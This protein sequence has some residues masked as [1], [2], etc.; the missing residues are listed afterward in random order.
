M[1]GG[2]GEGGGAEQGKVRRKGDVKGGISSPFNVSVSKLLLA[3]QTLD[4]F[5]KRSV[6]LKLQGGASVHRQNRR[7][8][9]REI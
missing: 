8:T 9:V 4:M 6:F 3:Q 1:E 5:L 7:R 2:G